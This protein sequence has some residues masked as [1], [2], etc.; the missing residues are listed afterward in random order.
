[1]QKVLFGETVRKCKAA[2]RVA[3][4]CCL[5]RGLAIETNTGF[6][7][8]DSYCLYSTFGHEIASGELA[9]LR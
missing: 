1:M 8:L 7:R 3:P 2:G 9:V 6:H 5:T 4:R